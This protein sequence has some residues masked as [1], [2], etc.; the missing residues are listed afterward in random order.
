MNKL[1]LQAIFSGGFFIFGI[2]YIL[3]FFQQRRNYTAL[4]FSL[5]CIL[6]AIRMP[7]WGD[8]MV[9]ALFPHMSYQIRAFLNYL[10]AYNL[11]P[12]ML[13]FVLSFYPGSYKKKLSLIVLAPSLF[14]NMLLL[15][16]MSFASYFTNFAYLI[17]LVQMLYLLL[18][19]MKAVVLKLED[20]KI[21]YVAACIYVFYSS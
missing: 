8:A 14:M 19:S 12:L 2:Y 7:I 5:L 13:L 16:S 11:V 15:T 6:T 4:V 20:A 9:E 21:V 18:I 3:V 1:L 10:T 17:M